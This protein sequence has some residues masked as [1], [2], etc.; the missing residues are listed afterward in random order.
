MLELL[1]PRDKCTVLANLMSTSSSLRTRALL[2]R[3]VL[4][5]P[6]HTGKMD[7]DVGDILSS[8]PESATEIYSEHLEQLHRNRIYRQRIR[9]PQRT[10][11]VSESKGYAVSM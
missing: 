6:T 11:Q 4:T 5:E 3:G 9:T 7:S 10:V 8:T 2:S 1:T